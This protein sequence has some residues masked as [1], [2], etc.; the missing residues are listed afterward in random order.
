MSRV[1]NLIT[2]SYLTD[3]NHPGFCFIKGPSLPE[4]YN[5][6]PYYRHQNGLETAKK[7]RKKEINP[8]I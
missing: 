3:I 8:D 1:G 5:L 2:W 4:W 7:K 6:D